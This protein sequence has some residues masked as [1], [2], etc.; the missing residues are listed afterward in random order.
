MEVDPT[1]A[2]LEADEYTVV[3]VAEAAAVRTH[4]SNQRYQYCYCVPNMGQM[5]HKDLI[6]AL[7]P[8][9]SNTM[10]VVVDSKDMEV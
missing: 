8:D 3:E 10:V 1:G 5:G 2:L 4:A 6:V 9:N 7:G